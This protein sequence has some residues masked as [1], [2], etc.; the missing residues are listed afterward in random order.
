MRREIHDLAEFDRAAAAGDL[1]D[2]VI[3]GL[4]LSAR[5]P[6]VTATS[7]AGSVL[8]GC[9]LADDA[10][11]HVLA[12]G[13]LVFP[14]LPG[15]PFDPYRPCLYRHGEL[16]T[17]VRRGVEGSFARDAL[18]SR[19]WAWSRRHDPRRLPLL[20]ALARRLHDLAIDDALADHL[21]GRPDV[22]AVMGGHEVTRGSAV[23]REVARLGRLCARRGWLV[24]T[25]GGPGAM[26]AANLGAWC[27]DAPDHILDDCVDLLAD[28]PDWRRPD[29][30]LEA[31]FR[32]L[33]R[34]PD[35]HENL[36]VPTWFYGHEP[37][38]QFATHVAKYFANSLREEGLLAIATR[39]VVFA[40]G[41]AGTLQEV[42]QDAT[43]NHYG[44]FGVVSP[45]VFL[46]RE[47][48]TEVL[49]AADLLT[50]LADGRPYR[51]SI[52]V[53]DDAAAAVAFLDDHPAR[54]VPG[55]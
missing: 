10:L 19:I 20:D 37:T 50:R 28:A 36:A 40:P 35:G 17:G 49:P 42:F 11:R 15:L 43:Q 31:G 21:A 47:H 12:T 52:G 8:L 54:P 38:N 6:T 23:Y 26:E 46:G 9:E 53:V 41:S 22:V 4:D 48:W 13:G 34:V 39:G 24:T 1:V 14:P 32:A 3:Q 45:M 7:W 2:V 44:V 29:P 51:D 33:D 18:D 5:T 25:G 55:A 16:L 27:A 30:Y